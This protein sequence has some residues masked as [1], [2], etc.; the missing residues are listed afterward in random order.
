VVPLP[1]D[2]VD[3]KKVLKLLNQQLASEMEG[4]VRYLHH[5]FMVVGFSRDPIVSYF[6]KQA[7]EGMSH[8]TILGEKIT[9]LGGHP[10][11]AFEANWEPEAHSVKEML[12]INLKAERE[13]LK[14]YHALHDAVVGQDIALEDLVREFIRQET[15]HCEDLEKYLKPPPT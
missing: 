8:A 11:V 10:E 2:D 1:E 7:N 13:A 12:E 4:V 3:K 5:S 9:A 14:G 15:E 6:R